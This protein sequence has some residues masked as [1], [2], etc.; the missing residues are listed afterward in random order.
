MGLKTVVSC[1][2]I[3]GISHICVLM[4]GFGG[5][6]VD[7]TLPEEASAFLLLTVLEGVSVLWL[8]SSIPNFL[9]NVPAHIE[10]DNISM[11]CW[12]KLV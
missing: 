9:K 5:E 12:D 7:K 10:N 4:G 1:L 3:V 8:N 11:A 6:K 2:K